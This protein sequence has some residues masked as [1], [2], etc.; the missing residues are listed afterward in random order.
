MS[1]PLSEQEIREKLK[2]FL[3]EVGKKIVNGIAISIATDE[4]Y[5]TDYVEK[6]I[7]DEFVKRFTQYGNQREVVRKV[8]EVRNLYE[9]RKLYD[10]YELKDRR[11]L[12][13]DKIATWQG[14]KYFRN[15]I[16]DRLEKITGVRHDQ[17]IE[18]WLKAQQGGQSE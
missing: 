15:P 7:E 5:D 13:G 3:D 12:S 17:G 6:F 18:K 10:D 8:E 9:L 11:D 4:D 1:N 16:S 14:Y 2:P